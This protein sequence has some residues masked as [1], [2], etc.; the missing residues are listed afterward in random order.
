[1]TEKVDDSELPYPIELLSS[2]SDSNNT[3][4]E[5]RYCLFLPHSNDFD[6]SL[7]R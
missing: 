4:V 3:V 5:G 2:S 7:Y 6:V 1:M